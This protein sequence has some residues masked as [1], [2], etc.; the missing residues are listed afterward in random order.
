MPLKH[1]PLSAL[2]AS[3]RE[4]SS[5]ALEGIRPRRGFRTAKSRNNI[6]AQIHGKKP[7]S[8]RD[9]VSA[10]NTQNRRA[11]S[12][13]LAAH[14]LFFRDGILCNRGTSDDWLRQRCAGCLR[15]EMSQ[16]D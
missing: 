15:G 9:A 5:L 8:R 6:A 13:T 1:D 14:F 4:I 11:S 10:E 3:P 12:A 7:I 2:T 16:L